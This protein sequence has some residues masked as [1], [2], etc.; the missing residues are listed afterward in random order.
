MHTY[1]GI[2]NRDPVE[3]LKRLEAEAKKTGDYSRF[4][5]ML[6]EFKRDDLLNGD[7]EEKYDEYLNSLVQDY[8]TYEKISQVLESKHYDCISDCDKQAERIAKGI[9][10][11]AVDVDPKLEDIK[12]DYTISK[13][14]ANGMLINEDVQNKII[15]YY[16][17]KTALSLKSIDTYKEIAKKNEKI[18][19][20]ENADGMSFIERMILKKNALEVPN[21]TMQTYGVSTDGHGTVTNVEPAMYTS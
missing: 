5:E 2:I 20:K 11:G 12:T 19:L 14:I 21:N 18:F 8:D 10:N 15:G 6:S 9:R 13:R 7:K 4:V 1:P 3:Y 17:L 16:N